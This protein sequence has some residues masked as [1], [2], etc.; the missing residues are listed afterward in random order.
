MIENFQ[1]DAQGS[2]LDAISADLPLTVY[3]EASTSSKLRDIIST[4]PE[5]FKIEP[6]P[7][8]ADVIIFENDTRNY[9]RKSVEFRQWKN[10]C[11]VISEADLPS[12]YLPG[13]YTC[14]KQSILTENRVKTISYIISTRSFPHPHIDNQ[15]PLDKIIYTYSFVGGATSWVRKRLFSSL[16]SG[17]DVYIEPTNNYHNWNFS[18]SYKRLKSK[19]Q[20]EFAKVIGQS[21]FVICPR[22]AGSSSLRLFEVMMAGRVP[23]II[24]D[25]WVPI[26]QIPWSE[27]SITVSE[28]KLKD[29][30][31]IVR[32]YKPL[33]KEMAKKS[34]EAWETY[35]SPPND[36]KLVRDLL[37]E[38]QMNRDEQREYWIRQIFPFMDAIR[39]TKY[40]FRDIIKYYTL[41]FFDKAGIEF[42]YSLNRSIKYQLKNYEKK[43]NK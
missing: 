8:I 28:N 43:F 38:V 35:L 9:I 24:S 7:S 16:K 6:E 31:S 21:L 23:V 36:L 12:F 37:L 40:A 11:V 25:N 14:N 39:V 30:D 19:I 33:G 3:L 1:T 17:L 34:R 26:E 27:F 4:H 13:C 2:S 29:I 10:K 18:K 42:P 32:Q 20:K 5:L 22:G 41:L 15:F